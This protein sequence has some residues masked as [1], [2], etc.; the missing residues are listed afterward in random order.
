MANE[1]PLAEQINIISEEPVNTWFN[2]PLASLF[3]GFFYHYTSISAN[4]VTMLAILSGIAAGFLFAAG[5]YLTL[6]IGAL[7]YQLSLVLDCA[8][9]QLARLKGTSSEFGRILDGISDYIVGFSVLGGALWAM[10]TNFEGLQQYLII[11]ISQDIVLPL[12]LLGFASITIHSIAY[13]LIK[14]KF[15]SIV[16]TGIDQTVKERQDLEARFRRESR[17]MSSGKRWMMRIY[18]AYNSLQNSLLSVGAY[19][20]LSYTPAERAAI[21]KRERG[22]LRLWSFL[23]PNTHMVCIML[24]TLAGDLMFALWLAVVPFNVYYVFMLIL[25]KVRMSPR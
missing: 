3:V 14:T 1:T 25:T 20:R 8:D 22:F 24:S 12:A 23:G 2:R 16:K 11:P 5:T 17:S 4:Q 18:L 7:A 21:I 15:S 10:H 13:D 9:G 19:S 6:F